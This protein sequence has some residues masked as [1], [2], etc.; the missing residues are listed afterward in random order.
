M[1][2]AKGPFPKAGL[3]PITKS[4]LLGVGLIPFTSTLSCL[5]SYSPER[6]PVYRQAKSISQNVT[7]AEL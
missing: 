4:N 7:L 6:A 1:L 2:K 3:Y 5:N